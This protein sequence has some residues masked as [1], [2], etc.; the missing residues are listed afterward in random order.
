MVKKNVLKTGDIVEVLHPL[1][2]T[3]TLDLNGTL[4][5]LPFMADLIQY[6]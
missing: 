4:D 5:K 1:E 6:C 2:V 3:K